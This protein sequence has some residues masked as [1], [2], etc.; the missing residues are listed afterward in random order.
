[1]TMVLSTRRT[2]AE[3][4]I[5]QRLLKGQLQR[6]CAPPYLRS[7]C[8]KQTNRNDWGLW[9]CQIANMVSILHGVDPSNVSF[10]VAAKR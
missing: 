10:N 1:M 4:Y 9:L 3:K 8:P 6:S 7:L 5:F 2:V